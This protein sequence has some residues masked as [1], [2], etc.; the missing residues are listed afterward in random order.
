M[1]ACPTPDK[2]RYQ[3]QR[4]ALHAAIGSSST[5]AMGMRVYRCECTAWHVTKRLP[6]WSKGRTA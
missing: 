5:F 6:R 4:A 2:R 3:T 1:S